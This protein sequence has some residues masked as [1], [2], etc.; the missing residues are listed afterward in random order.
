MTIDNR[1]EAQLLM[2]RRADL[3]HQ[4]DIEGRSYAFATSKPTG[5]PPRGSASTI[6]RLS[7]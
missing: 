5:T 4:Q 2:P 6:G 3:A 7:R 1:A